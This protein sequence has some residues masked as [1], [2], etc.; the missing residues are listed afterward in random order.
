[1]FSEDVWQIIKEEA[2]ALHFS[3]SGT[4]MNGNNFDYDI[5]ICVKEITG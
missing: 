3:L 5:V 1:M 2:G 4:F